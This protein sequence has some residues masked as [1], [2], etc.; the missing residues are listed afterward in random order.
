MQAKGVKL[1]HAP[2][3]ESKRMQ[4]ELK[5]ANLGQNS[6]GSRSVIFNKIIY[7]F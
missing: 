1:H 4:M 5:S 2:W 3:I 6:R 7:D